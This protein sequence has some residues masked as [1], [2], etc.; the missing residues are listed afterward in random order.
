[1]GIAR[2]LEPDSSVAEAACGIGLMLTAF[3]VAAH[4]VFN[5]ATA[6]VHGA[7]LSPVSLL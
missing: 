1:M 3:A 2:E 6:T 4:V 5:I 7:Y